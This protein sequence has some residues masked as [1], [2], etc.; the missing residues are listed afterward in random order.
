MVV[1]DRRGAFTDRSGAI[2]R[3]GDRFT[4]WLAALDARPGLARDRAGDPID[5]ARRRLD[6]RF[7]ALYRAERC[8]DSFLAR[9]G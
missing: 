5:L 6:P 9:S 7:A 2:A 4:E 3:L 1:R 8:V